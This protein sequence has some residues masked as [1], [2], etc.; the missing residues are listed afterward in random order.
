[1]KN[2]LLRS[3]IGLPNSC[4]LSIQTRDH[5]DQRCSCID[6]S[7]YCVLQ[8]GSFDVEGEISDVVPVVDDLDFNVDLTID[9]NHE[10]DEE[11]D[12]GDEIYGPENAE[13]VLLK[14]GIEISDAWKEKFNQYKMTLKHVREQ[15][16]DIDRYKKS[17]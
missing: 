1:M 6:Y 3:R 9:V 7:S 17:S 8:R 13:D 11:M 15:T 16:S 12:V 4:L 5:G 10:Q 2:R 14:E